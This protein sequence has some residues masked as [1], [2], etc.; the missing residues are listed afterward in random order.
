MDDGSKYVRYPREA[1]IFAASCAVVFCILGILG[2]LV[3]VLALIRCPKLR[4]HATTAFV[5]S[6]CIS[7]L[8]F[9][10]VNLPLTAARYIYEKWILGDALCKLF[11]VFF[12]G[13]VA[14]SVL[15]MVAITL[16][17][18]ILI[19]CYEYYSKLYSKISICMQLLCTWGTAFLIM[20]PPLTGAWGQLGLDPSTFSCTILEKEGKSP[21]KII[22]LVGFA[23]PCIVI[24]LAYSCIYCSVRKSKRKLRSHQPIADAR[25]AKREKDDNRLTKLMALIFLCFLFCFLPLMLVNVFDDSIRYPVFHVLASISA[26]ASSVVNPFIYAASNRQYRSAYK[27]LLRTVKSSMAFSD[28]RHSNNSLRSKYEKNQSVSFRPKESSSAI[29]G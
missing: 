14:V 10:T 15:N 4:N 18:Y 12:Y 13:N 7:D 6:L 5:L 20:L 21:K 23:L 28:S 1:T 3:T 25:T 27:K 11:P 16:N 9:C 2:N 8:L 19:S 24:I 26:W 22:F 29:D 17:R